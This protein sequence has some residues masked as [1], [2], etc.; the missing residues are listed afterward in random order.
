MAA[1]E[2]WR[3][4]LGLDVRLETTNYTARRPDLIGRSISI[5][6]LHS[7]TVG[8]NTEPKGR[9]MSPELGGANRGMELPDEILD[10]TWYAGLGATSAEQVIQGNIALQDFLSKWTLQAPTVQR[11]NFAAVGTRVMEWKPQ[12]DTFGTINSPERVVINQ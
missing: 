11:I 2:M 6:F 1:A 8:D 10:K 4:N 9:L 3:D 7:R 5:P 12:M